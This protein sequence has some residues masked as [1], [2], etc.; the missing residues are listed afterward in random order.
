MTQWKSKLSLPENA[1]PLN[2]SARTKL[3]LGLFSYPVLQAADIL[4]HRATHVPVGAD[5]AQ[6]LEFAREIAGG[7]NHLYPYPRTATAKQDAGED[8]IS[9]ADQPVLVQ[10]ETIISPARRVM[11]L[12][13]P[14]MKMSKSDPNPKSRILITDSKEDIHAKI[15]GAVTD[16]VPGPVTY[17]PANRPGVSNL[18]EI[19]AH[20]E[21]NTPDEMAEHS[22]GFSLREFKEQVAEIIDF[23]VSRIRERYE[24]NMQGWDVVNLDMA[25]DYGAEEARIRAKETMRMVREAIGFGAPPK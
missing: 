12:T 9:E 10:P 18:L 14:T 15:R 17:S 24:E 6:H 16:S 8:G 4:V 11:S 22:Q 23:H 13:N 2:E 7:F 5:Q 3:K 25:A 1:S 20:L 19:I 21:G